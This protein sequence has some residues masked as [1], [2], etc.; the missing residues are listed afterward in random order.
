MIHEILVGLSAL[1]GLSAL[2]VAVT[3]VTLY[4]RACRRPGEG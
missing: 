4:V 3:G 2:A 1:L